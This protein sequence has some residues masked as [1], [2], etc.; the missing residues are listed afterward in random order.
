MMLTPSFLLLMLFH[1]SDAPPL[2][3]PDVL[4]IFE[5]YCLECHATGIRMGSF[6]CDT[7]AGVMRGATH[8]PVVVPYK[9]EESRLYLSLAGRI[10]PVMPL[11][12]RSLTK[13]E[14]DIVRRWI[15]SGAQSK[16]SKQH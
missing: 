16:T 13:A 5:K 2:F 12:D 10:T 8:G 7:H 4:P 9:S 11:S 1:A 15:D 6:E 14:L 3:E